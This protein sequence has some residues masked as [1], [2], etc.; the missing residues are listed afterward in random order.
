VSL[1]S[2][3]RQVDFGYFKHWLT[4]KQI[5]RLRFLIQAGNPAKIA[6]CIKKEDFC[7]KYRISFSKERVMDAKTYV[8]KDSFKDKR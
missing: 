1:F 5:M 4:L 3:V 6:T 7:A 8:Q 2:P